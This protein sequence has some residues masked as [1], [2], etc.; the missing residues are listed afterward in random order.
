VW[1]VRA[2]RD[3]RRLGERV[4]GRHEWVLGK[5]RAGPWEGASGGT[6]AEASGPGAHAGRCAAPALAARRER[7]SAFWQDSI[8]V[9]PCL[10]A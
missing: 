4:L 2:A 9:C 10:N 8:S 3:T 5:A 7:A 1:R 6:D